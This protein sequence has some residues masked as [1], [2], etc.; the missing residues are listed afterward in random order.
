MTHEDLAWVQGQ[1]RGC[2]N[3][4]R[5]LRI[6]AEC[7]CLTDDEL[8]THLGYKNMAAFRA[9][10]PQSKHPVGPQ[11]ERIYHP[12]PPDVMLESVLRYYGG[13]RLSTVCSLMGYTQPVTREAIRHRV[14]SW[15]K[16]HPALAAGMPPKRPNTPIKEKTMELNIDATGLPAYAYARSPYTGGIVRIVRGERALF[17][18]NSVDELNAAGVTRAQAAAMYNGAMY[19]WGTPYSD[20]SNYSE[21]GSYVGPDMEDPHG[22]EC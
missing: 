7:L 19:G 22:T 2:A 17:G 4:R 20:P 10:H 3:A 21:A 14:C 5:Q 16:K 15:R 11:V 6:C 18:I 1:L 12:V 9:A 13:E 8:L